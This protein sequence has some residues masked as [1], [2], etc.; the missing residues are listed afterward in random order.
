M[1]TR[2]RD[3]AEIKPSGKDV[4]KLLEL[5]PVNFPAIAVVPLHFKN[6]QSDMI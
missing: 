6:L 5:L 2:S 1:K 4:G 3:A